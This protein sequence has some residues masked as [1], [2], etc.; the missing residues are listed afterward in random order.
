MGKEDIEQKKKLDILKKKEK[1]I[2]KNL[3]LKKKN[4]EGEQKRRGKF[5]TDKA[6]QI[7]ELLRTEGTDYIYKL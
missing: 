5:I 3:E 2:K 4:L 1:E 6:R 7:K